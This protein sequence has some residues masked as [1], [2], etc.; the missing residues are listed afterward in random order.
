MRQSRKANVVAAEFCAPGT[1]CSATGE[2]SANM[3]TKLA[4]SMTIRGGLKEESSEV[5][6]W[7]C[8]AWTI[9][10]SHTLRRSC[11]SSNSPRRR[12]CRVHSPTMKSSLLRGRCYLNNGQM[13]ITRLEIHL[14]HPDSQLSTWTS[15]LELPKDPPLAKLFI[16]ARRRMSVALVLRA[17]WQTTQL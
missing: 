15:P 11:P 14:P 9:I 7:Q 12:P 2:H 13:R 8:K 5:L 16:A 1:F 17:Y 6:L 10:L 4:L 3:M